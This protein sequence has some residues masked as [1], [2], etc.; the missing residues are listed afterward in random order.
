MDGAFAAV[1]AEG[2]RHLPAR[3]RVE[4]FAGSSSVGTAG[5]AVSAGLF[6]QILSLPPSTSRHASQRDE[7][8]ETA[9][10]NHAGYRSNTE[11]SGE[12]QESARSQPDS[13]SSSRDDEEEAA[14]T[15]DQV[16][17][18][19]ANSVSNATEE[20]VLAAEAPP[21][22]LTNTADDGAKLKNG[23][24]STASLDENNVAVDDVKG[25]GAPH[26]PQSPLANSVD[27]SPLDGNELQPTETVKLGTDM[28]SATAAAEQAELNESVG[29]N[30]DGSSAP[31]PEAQAEGDTS[32]DKLS[33]VIE[34]PATETS[35]LASNSSPAQLDGEAPQRGQGRGQQRGKWYQTND[36]AQTAGQEPSAA[37]AN[38]P[39]LTAAL[40]RPQDAGANQE[41]DS[42]VPLTVDSTSI[43]TTPVPTDVA[44]AS[45]FPANM[46]E[47]LPQSSGAS[48]STAV[49]ASEA[50]GME[51][52]SLTE[53]FE[54]QNSATKIERQESKVTPSANQESDQLTQAERVRLVQRVARSFARLG[55]MGGQI[56]IRLHPPQLG[57]LNVQVRMEGRTMTAKLTTEST[58]ARDA[59]LES[60]PVLRGRL[61]EQG[62][63]VA[64]FQVDVA[65]NH[66]DAAS[67]QSHSGAD[68][69][70]GSGWQNGR[71]VDYRRVSAMHHRATN[72][73]VESQAPGGSSG[74]DRLSPLSIDVQA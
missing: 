3:Y 48:S 52:K 39:A 62:F 51:S 67:G 31:M 61:A 27:N 44:A 73:T 8:T 42:P 9:H 56:N 66:A 19:T 34:T 7:R 54:P 35:Q 57:S 28:P 14:T 71:P 17:V 13:E 25:E 46:A 68:Q 26:Q 55:P 20:T 38:S 1:G 18:L 60:L 22:E 59:I 4:M 43:A 33:A 12:T 2:N 64:S 5:S 21:A 6:E 29:N 10:T 74:L 72:P 47:V 70:D 65:D 53:S 37:G 40:E 49:Q 15:S 69:S 41:V 30:L 32:Q 50:G 45:P 11:V 36:N 23:L 63:E 58:T 16:P 24:H